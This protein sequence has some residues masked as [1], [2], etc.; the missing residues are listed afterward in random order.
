MKSYKRIVAVEKATRILKHLANQKAPVSAPAIA[1]AIK[2][3][4][5]TVMCH[6]VT[7]EE[8]GFV[9]SITDHWKLGLG[10][11]LL[12]HKIIAGLEAERAR[13]SRDIQELEEAERGE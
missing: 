4:L 6:L 3:P 5:P 9:Q 13:I 10:L 12:R 1:E 7:L 11:G 2:L 8:A